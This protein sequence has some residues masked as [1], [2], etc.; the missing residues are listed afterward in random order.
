MGKNYDL[1]GPTGRAALA[2]G[3]ANPAWFRPDVDPKDIRV[4]MQKSDA[5]A[6]RDTVLWLGLMIVFAITAT[7][8]WPTWWSVPFWLAYGVLYGSGADSRWHECGHK[9][10]FKTAWMNTIVYHIACFMMMRNPAVFRA[11][12]V[13]HHTD[14]IIVG[15]DPEIVAM[16]PPDLINLALRAVGVVDVYDAFKGMVRHARG[17]IS[18]EEEMYVAPTDHPRIFR[19]ARIWL[20]I[21]AAT[22]I[23]A[24]WTAS[25]IPLL[26]IGLPRM[27]GAWHHVMT[28]V[29]QHLGLAENVSDHRLNTRSVMMNRLNRFIYLNMNYHLEHH[30]FTM[31]PYY[32]LP[33]LHALI[34]HDL[35]AP[36][37]SIIS[38][39]KRLLPVLIKQLNYED[40]VILRDLPDGATPY[41]AEADK[42]RRH[43]I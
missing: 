22:L 11:S 6:L 10:A 4:L 27:Y 31:V 9:T 3:T 26:L 30:M 38:A 42:L 21:Y 19:T 25:I 18:G 43:A 16:R 14:T 7:L 8:L 29:L 23:V 28:G 37:P 2:N 35:P 32:N 12:H 24:I 39:Y 20:A 5:I 41:R 40:A 13:R 15:R 17:R 33:K 1:T 36:D 34:K